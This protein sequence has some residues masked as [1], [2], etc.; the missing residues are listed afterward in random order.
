MATILVAHALTPSAQSDSIDP[1]IA[2]LVASVSEDRLRQLLSTLVAFGTRHTNSPATPGRGIAA[3]RQWIQDEM[4]RSSPRL[5]VSFDV[6]QV[7]GKAEPRVGADV[8]LRNVMAVLPGQSNRR[9]YVTAHYDSLNRATDATGDAPGANDNGS[10]TVLVMELARAFAEAGLNLEP[11]LVFM[12]TGAE[13]QGL[14][15]ARLHAQRMVEAKL[16]IVAVFNNDI[17]GGAG[18]DRGIADSASIR[19]FSEGPHDSPSRALA[20]FARRVAMRYVPSHRVRLFDRRDRLGR[21]GDHTAFNQSGFAAIGF[22]ESRENFSRQHNDRDTLDGV[23]FPYLAQNAR[24]NAAA[25]AE[26]A[27]APQMPVPAGITT[28]PSWAETS[29]LSWKAAPGAAAY[30]VYWRE[31][32]GPDWERSLLVGTATQHVVPHVMVDDY[33]FGVSAIGRDGHES[34]IASFTVNR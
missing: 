27:L 16:P 5:R 25:I 28:T 20:L 3:A 24:V 23:S 8:E 26:L 22:R 34:P 4:Q 9:I 21:G 7:S 10:G 19:I 32:W 30:R 15:G 18:D 1:S 14:V 17:V 2:K 13:E 31:A 11:T 6:H 12:A 29:T 33:V